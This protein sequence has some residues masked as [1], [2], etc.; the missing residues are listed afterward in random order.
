[1]ISAG[2]PGFLKVPLPSWPKRLLP[3]AQRLPSAVRA[4]V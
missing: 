1:M 3:Q 2:V 4:R